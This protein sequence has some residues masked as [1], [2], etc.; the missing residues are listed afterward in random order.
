MIWQSNFNMVNLKTNYFG[1]EYDQFRLRLFMKYHLFIKY[2]TGVHPTTL[3]QR[4]L[5][6]YYPND[7]QI[8][9]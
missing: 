4:P 5:L 7:I 3:K 2:Y 8:K 6:L 1:R 9:L